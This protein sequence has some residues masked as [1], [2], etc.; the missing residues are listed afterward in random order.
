MHSYK[1]VAKE[2]LIAWNDVN[3]YYKIIVNGNIPK[4][5]KDWKEVYLHR[6]ISMDS[7]LIIEFV[8]NM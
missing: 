7:Y 5:E 4:G 8:Y 3:S 1:N 6:K 2:C